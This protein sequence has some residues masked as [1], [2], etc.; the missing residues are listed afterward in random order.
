M[1][2][3]YRV[4]GWSIDSLPEITVYLTNSLVD[5]HFAGVM[6]LAFPGLIVRKGRQ[7]IDL[8]SLTVQQAYH[9]AGSIPDET[10]LVDSLRASKELLSVLD[11]CQA[12]FCLD[13]YRVPAEEDESPEEWPYTD[14]GLRVYQ[15]KYRGSDS[16]REDVYEALLGAIQRHPVLRKIE[17]LVA[18]PPSSDHGARPDCPREWS[19]S[20][21]RQLDLPLA[22]VRRTRVANSQKNFGDPDERKAN[23][24]GSME[25]SEDIQG[26]RILVIDDLYMLGDSVK[27]IARAARVAGAAE[28]FSLCAVK[29]AKG[30]QG[31]NFQ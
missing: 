1:P 5:Q 21:A 26:R 22:A 29:T 12:S 17:I 10:T 18:M 25:A 9:L 19:R 14:I 2:I 4:A 11:S 31:Y 28:V 8:D 7:D 24:Q 16:A 20:L 13:M 15:A 6:Q 3:C 23:Q 30:C 27:E